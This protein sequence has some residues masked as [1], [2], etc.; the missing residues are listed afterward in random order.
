MTLLQVKSPLIDLR[1]APQ[2]LISQFGEIDELR[3]SQLLMNE[4][5]L[6]KERKREW[7]FVEAIEQERFTKERGWHGYEGWVHGD[8]IEEVSSPFK[9]THAVITPWSP[10]NFPF[11]TLLKSASSSR[12][13]PQKIDRNTLIED[14]LKFIGAPYLWGG[15]GPYSLDPFSSVD[16]SGLISLLFRAQG[17]M[18][19]RDAH[20]QFLKATPLTKEE[21]KKGDLIFL[22]PIDHPQ[23]RV[24][25]VIIYNEEEFIEAPRTGQNVRSLPFKT[26]YK[27]EKGHIF[28][29]DRPKVYTATYGSFITS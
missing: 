17:K 22:T 28:L 6:L 16:C 20:D 11:G 12:L 29:K 2:S 7:L 1:A 18:I 27:E 26:H 13:L 14:A 23:K 10:Q 24:T 19:P 4:K 9:P 21:L 5:L 8:E 15:R 25:H 3:L